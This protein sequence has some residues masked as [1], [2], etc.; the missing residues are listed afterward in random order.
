M[1]EGHKIIPGLD[2]ADLTTLLYASAT[3]DMDSCT[4]TLMMTLDHAGYVL[5]R[6][7]RDEIDEVLHR[8]K[9][10]GSQ[11]KTKSE[12][13]LLAVKNGQAPEIEDYTYNKALNRYELNEEEAARQ[14]A[15]KEEISKALN[16]ATRMMIEALKP[17]TEEENLATQAKA[18]A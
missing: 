8:L 4:A 9:V 17:K 13:A 15:K 6:K 10:I 14:E 7:L 3:G 18:E 11:L 2:P 5:G 1:S 12:K 16:K